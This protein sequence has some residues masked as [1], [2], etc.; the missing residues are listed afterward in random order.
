MNA[1]FGRAHWCSCVLFMRDEVILELFSFA[2][3]EDVETSQSGLAYGVCFGMVFRS[4]E[5]SL[6]FLSFAF[7]GLEWWTSNEMK[8]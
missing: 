8:T 2:F 5:V 1:V 3:K 4:D 6:L 7:K